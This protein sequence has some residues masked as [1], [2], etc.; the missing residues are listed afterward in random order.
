MNN[1][2]LEED[3]KRVIE[4]VNLKPLTGKTIMVS[5]ASGL[6]GTHLLYSIKAFIEAGNKIEKLYIL[7]FH[8]LPK[9]LNWIEDCEWAE[10]LKGDLTDTIFLNSLPEADIIIHGAGYAQPSLFMNAQ[11]KTL[12]LNTIATFGLIEK[13]KQGGKFLFIS[14]SAV[15]TGCTQLPFQEGQIGNSNTTHERS[16]Y[17]EGK[18]CGEA[19]CQAYRKKGIDA[20]AVRFSITYGPGTKKGDVRALNSF[21]ERGILEQKIT[22]MDE[23]NA[24][25]VY[26]YISDAVELLWDILLLGKES[27]YNVG[28]H[29]KTSIYELASKVG[30]YLNV[31][32]IRTEDGK[33]IAG[34]ILEEHLDMTKSETEF[35][36]QHYITIEEGLKRTVQWN[37]ENL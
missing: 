18:R 26:C 29:S 36:K 22:L 19:I 11:D 7:I 34:A 1:Q 17:I 25:K 12:K 37:K 27:I 32:V 35:Q 21:M 28:G 15:Y 9:H 24:Q 33:G 3:A 5:G 20:K 23:G 13:V 16:C 30:E 6:I 31:P 8:T 14:S 2:I 10:I 4:R